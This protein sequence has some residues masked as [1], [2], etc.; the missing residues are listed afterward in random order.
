ML[1]APM[2]VD[3]ITK[4]AISMLQKHG[5]TGSCCLAA[6]AAQGHTQIGGSL[7]L[8]Q[9][10]TGVAACHKVQ[11]LQ[12]VPQASTAASNHRA[13]GRQLALCHGFGVAALG[14]S[15][16]SFQLPGTQQLHSGVGQSMRVRQFSSTPLQGSGQHQPTPQQ[17]LPVAARAL[18][19]PAN[20]SVGSSEGWQKK[21]PAD[22][23]YYERLEVCSGCVQFMQRLHMH[24]QAHLRSTAGPKY[25]NCMCTSSCPIFRLWCGLHAGM[26]C[27]SDMQVAS[28]L[29]LK[30]ARVAMPQC[31]P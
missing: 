4:T 30:L 3:T 7:L 26:H 15:T 25:G 20:S 31:A 18:Q 10:C 27:C 13:Q 5:L 9:Y 19:F 6:S 21:R 12:A 11:M 8:Q 14:V 2:Y 1:V 24:K 29:P 16:A 23:D 17:Q 28:W 22:M